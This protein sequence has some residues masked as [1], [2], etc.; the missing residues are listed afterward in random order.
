MYQNK[1]DYSLSEPVTVCA[2]G[3]GEKTS[4]QCVTS[5]LSGDNDNEVL[6]AAA[7]WAG[8]ICLFQAPLGEAVTGH[9]KQKTST[10]LPSCV[11]RGHTDNVR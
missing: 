5:A 8:E 6:L 9:K 2:S 4:F 10:V 7:G 11:L 3:A 1:A